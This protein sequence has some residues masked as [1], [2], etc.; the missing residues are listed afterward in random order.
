[1]NMR[2]IEQKDN[3][4]IAAIIR[5]SLESANLAIEGTAYTDPH[6]D[7]LFEYYQS[8]THAAYWIAEENGDIL[9]GVGIAP[10]TNGICELQKLYL[11]PNAQGKGA[12]KKLMDT[13]LQ[14]ASTYYEACYLETRQELTAATGLY[15]RYGFSLLSEP[16]E[17]S[18][19]S[20]M[21]AW[22]L[23]TFSS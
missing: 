9:G 19:H 2:P 7:Q 21:D 13:A 15:Q 22:Y 12:G 1:M 16:I 18:E 23:K 4:Y 20:A 3:P 11:S 17:G 6:L 5:Q 10:F 8:L 14:Y